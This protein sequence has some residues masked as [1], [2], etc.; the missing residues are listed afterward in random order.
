MAYTRDCL[1]MHWNLNIT[2]G[3]AVRGVSTTRLEKSGRSKTTREKGLTISG[4]KRGRNSRLHGGIVAS[5]RS[6][7]VARIGFAVDESREIKSRKR[8]P[9]QAYLE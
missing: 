4:M 8:L 7:R 5:R 6:D 9:R 3:E 1:R 2:L